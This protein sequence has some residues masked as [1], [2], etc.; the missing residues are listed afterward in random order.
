MVDERPTKRRQHKDDGP[1]KRSCR[2]CGT[3]FTATGEVG[4]CSKDC[5]NAWW[6]KRNKLMRNPDLSMSPAEVIAKLDY[7]AW[8][9]T[10]PPWVRH[11]EPWDNVVVRRVR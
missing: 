8:L 5:R 11:P 4:F 9:A 10:Q 3:V 1:R 7:D 2:G 6:A